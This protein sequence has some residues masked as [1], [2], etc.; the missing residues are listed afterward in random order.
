MI[1]LSLKSLT[2]E[3][4]LKPFHITD[5]PLLC[6]NLKGNTFFGQGRNV[7]NATL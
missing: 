5:V 1:G 4:N 6:S 3:S 2:S 7:D